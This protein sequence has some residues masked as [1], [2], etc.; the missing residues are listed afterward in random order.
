MTISVRRVEAS[1]WREVK[2]LRLRA[3]ADDSA[4]IAFLDTV[5]NA[6]AQPDGYWQERARNAAGDSA[7]AQIV[8]ISEDADWIGSVTVIPHRAHAD[9]GLIVG[10]YL[11]PEQ[12][13]QGVFEAMLDEAS[14]WAASRDLR[15]LY[16]EVHVDNQRAQAAYRRNG[17][18]KC[19]ELTTEGFGAEYEMRRSVP[20]VRRTC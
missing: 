6:A 16:L 20:R 10:V 8:A 4:P 18:E 14:D 5:E 15:E 9:A 3:L 12:R 2:T 13:G 17:F 7:A 11:A 1:E 19:G